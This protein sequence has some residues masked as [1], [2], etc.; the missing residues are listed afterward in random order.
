MTRYVRRE[1]LAIA[2]VLVMGAATASAAP[3]TLGQWNFNDLGT[4]YAATN[5]PWSPSTSAPEATVTPMTDNSLDFLE[6]NDTRDASSG[7]IGSP[8]LLLGLSSTGVAIVDANTPG[9]PVSTVDYLLFNLTANQNNLNLT[10][11]SFKLGQSVGLNQN[12]GGTIAQN[13][14]YVQVFYSTNGTDFSAVG[15]EQQALLNIADGVAKFSGMQTYTVDLTSIAALS[16]GDTVNFRIGITD[17]RGS[18]STSMAS[19][20]DDFQIDGEVGVPEPTSLVLVGLATAGLLAR[21]RRG[22]TS[23]V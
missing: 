23:L 13:A 2:A 12:A 8:G 15:A 20:W 21:R 5:G 19:Y 16:S 10:S 22:R 7:G 11:L 6:A 3:I 17:N 9:T 4:A 1:T 14:T 18:S